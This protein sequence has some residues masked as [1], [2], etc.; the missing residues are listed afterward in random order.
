LSIRFGFA[1]NAESTK[2]AVFVPL[3]G[4]QPIASAAAALASQLAQ[5]SRGSQ[6]VRPGAALSITTPAAASTRWQ[7][8]VG[9]SMRGL[10]RWRRA[11]TV[12]LC[13]RSR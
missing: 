2:I 1:K 13:V 8:R 6:T 9:A 3:R 7:L 4:D 12:K 10:W 5:E 11:Q